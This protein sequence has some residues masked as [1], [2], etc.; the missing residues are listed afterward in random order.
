MLCILLQP[1]Y[2]MLHIITYNFDTKHI[3]MKVIHIIEE[4]KNTQNTKE[5]KTMDSKLTNLTLPIT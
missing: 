2:N 5:D 3:K 4:L 1:F